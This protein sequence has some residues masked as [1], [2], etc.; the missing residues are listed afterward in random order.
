[1]ARNGF[2]DG[3]HA[4]QFLEAENLRRVGDGRG[5]RDRGFGGEVDDLQLFIGGEVIEH[6]V[7]EEAIELGFG[8]RVSAFEFDGVLRGEHEERLGQTVARAAHGAGMLLHG[9]EQ[10]GLRL[11]R[12]AIDLIGEQDVGE[13]GAL[14]EGPGAA[15]AGGIFFDDVGAGDVGRHQVG[16]ELDAFEIEAE[17]GG[18]GCARA[19][20][21]RCRAGR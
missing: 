14:D 6:G 9:F 8:Q 11:G 19:V 12:R 2:G 13:D 4:D 7:E 16:R 5:L 17:R 21:S 20:F 3:H 18:E 1:M 15:A 10:C